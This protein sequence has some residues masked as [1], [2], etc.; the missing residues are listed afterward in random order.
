MSATLDI[1][2]PADQ[3]EGTRSQILRWLKNVGE[4]VAEAEPLIEIETDKVTVEVP[5]PGAGVLREILKGE[6]D[7]IEPGE[8]LGRLE[9]ADMQAAVESPGVVDATPA[10]AA[11]PQETPA[12]RARSASR[13]SPAVSRLIAER[14]LD[15]ATLR[16]TGEGGRITVD[17]VLAHTPGTSSRFVPHSAIRKRIAEPAAHGSARHH[18]VPGRPVSG[19]GSQDG[20]PKRIRGGRRTADLHRVLPLRHR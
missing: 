13:L 20:A 10:E 16:G 14:G 9:P 12:P 17:D 11:A 3:T 4:P 5:S 6:Q 8:V 2:A 15:P 19:D 7:E 1:R 18:G